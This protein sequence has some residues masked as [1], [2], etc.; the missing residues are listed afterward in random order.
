MMKANSPICERLIPVCTATF[1]DSPD[2][3]TPAADITAFTTMV[4]SES[5]T[6]GSQYCIR[7]CG[8]TIIPTDTK[9]MAPNRSLMLFIS[10][11]IL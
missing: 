7:I 3:S 11:S 4:T 8:S 10:F 1:S 9:K 2:I 6:M 5:M